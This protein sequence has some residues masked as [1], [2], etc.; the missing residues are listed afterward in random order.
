MIVSVHI[1]DL[2]LRD[3]GH[4]LFRRPGQRKAPG[5]VTADPVI[6]APLGGALLSPPNP[7]RVGMIAAWDGDAALDRFLAAHSV[8]RKLA[9]GW[10]ARLEPVRVFGSW[11]AMPGLPTRE[12]PVSDEEPVAVLTLGRLRLNRARDF[13]RSAAPA[14]RAAVASG[15]M[16]AGT[17]LARPPRLVSTFSLWRAAGEMRAY[18]FGRD[19]AHQAAVRA[20]RDHPFHHE[21]AFIRFRPYASAGAWDGRDPLAGRS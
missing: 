8:G 7:R 3:A 11:A 19:G 6:T 17:A 14:E 20:D 18:A 1:A 12:R 2:P 9:G 21:S 4:V 13:L 5:L 16:L 15:A 10:H